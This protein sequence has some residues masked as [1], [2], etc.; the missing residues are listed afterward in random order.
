MAACGHQ[1]GQGEQ[2]GDGDEVGAGAVHEGLLETR[3]KIDLVPP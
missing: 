3:A 1:A 2:E